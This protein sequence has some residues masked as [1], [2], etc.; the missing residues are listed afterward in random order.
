MGTSNQSQSKAMKRP[1]STFLLLV[2]FSVIATLILTL[3]HIDETA[4]PLD[5]YLEE[6]RDNRVT[7]E[8]TTN[9]YE[10]TLEELKTYQT[11]EEDLVEIGAN[12]EQAQAIIQSSE[13]HHIDP[14]H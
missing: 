14:K 1:L 2:S 12:H 9:L 4:I 13:L 6:I 3:T 7:I 10:Q 11:L 8:E 5:S